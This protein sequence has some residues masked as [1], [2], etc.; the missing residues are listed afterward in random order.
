MIN[1]KG[2]SDECQDPRRSSNW[3]KTS[4]EAT[5][6]SHYIADFSNRQETYQRELSHEIIAQHLLFGFYQGFRT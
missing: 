1:V 5:D 6:T 3:A 4:S 2:E